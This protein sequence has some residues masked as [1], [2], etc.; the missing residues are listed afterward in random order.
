MPAQDILS[1]VRDFRHYLLWREVDVSKVD[2]A[3]RYPE[4]IR[5]WKVEFLDCYLL[6]PNGPYS[7]TYPNFD[8]GM[9]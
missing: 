7:F 5:I 9:S 1:F 3:T 8:T 6:A 2:L 4:D